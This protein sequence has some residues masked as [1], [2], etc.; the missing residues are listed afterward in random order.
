MHGT[1]DR[2]PITEMPEVVDVGVVGV[3]DAEYGERPVAF[4]SGAAEIYPA[5]LERRVGAFCET[6][7]GTIKR[8]VRYV[9]LPELPRSAT[10]KMRRRELR[11]M[12]AAR[13]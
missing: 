5:E 8:P 4:I 1:H 12:L 13:R 7:L 2:N 3:Q 9:V 10:G 11:D 6:R